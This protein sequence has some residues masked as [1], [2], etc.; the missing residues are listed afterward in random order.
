MRYAI[1]EIVL[2]VI[3]IL[4]AL[5]INNW[6]ENRKLKIDERA[7]LTNLSIEF[8]RKLDELEGKNQGRIENIKG[9]DQL[10]QIISNRDSI[11]NDGEIVL[12]DGSEIIQLDS[13]TLNKNS[14]FG[15]KNDTF[16]RFAIGKRYSD[17]VLRITTR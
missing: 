15:R 12:G 13:N 8:N 6:N 7:L 16:I 2:V 5:Q 3:G 14:G 9:I 10:L 4:I 17:S 11:I 1:G